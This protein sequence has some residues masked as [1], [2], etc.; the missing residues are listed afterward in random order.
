[1]A[2]YLGRMTFD[3]ADSFAEQVG[4]AVQNVGITPVPGAR[5]GT[6][7]QVKLNLFTQSPNDPVSANLLLRKQ[8]RS[9]LNNPGVLFRGLYISSDE[10]PEQNAWYVIQPTT[11]DDGTG[12]ST[13]LAAG[14]F[15]ASFQASKVGRYTNVRPAMQIIMRDRTSGLYAADVKGQFYYTDF[16]TYRSYWS[17]LGQ[18]I[19]SIAGPMAP[20]A[21]TPGNL[22]ENVTVVG[23]TYASAT[24]SGM[25]ASTARLGA[26]S[27]DPGVKAV[28]VDD[29][30]VVVAENYAAG[31]MPANRIAGDVVI[32]DRNKGVGPAR[33]LLSPQD[34]SFEWSVGSWVGFT[35]CTI[36]TSYAQAY[37]GNNSMAMTATANGNMAAQQP[38][39]MNPPTIPVIGGQTYTAVAY[40]RA[41]TVSRNATLRIEFGYGNP[42]S[43][44]YVQYVSSAVPDSSTGW[45][46]LTVTATAPA[47]AIGA[48]LQVYISGSPTAGE[49]HYVDAVGLYQGTN[50]TYS[51][52][53]VV[54]P[55]TSQAQPD[56]V[57][58]YGPDYPWDTNGTF[59]DAPV[60]TNGMVRVSLVKVGSSAR[61]CLVLE[62]NY[63]GTWSEVGR[64]QQQVN[65]TGSG[66]LGYLDT[67]IRGGVVEWRPDRGVVSMTF[68]S[69]A[70]SGYVWEVVVILQRGWLG[71]RVEVYAP[72]GTTGTTN[73]IS[74]QFIQ[75]SSGVNSTI[76]APIPGSIIKLN[77]TGSITGGTFTLTI[78]GYATGAITWSSTSAT[79]LANIQAAVRALGFRNAIDALVTS[80]SGLGVTAAIGIYGYTSAGSVT[81]NTGSL[82]GTG[83]GS[84][85]SV[86]YPAD[87]NQASALSTSTTSAVPYQQTPAVQVASTAGTG[88]TTLSTAQLPP[89]TGIN[90][91][92]WAFLR[93]QNATAGFNGVIMAS[94]RSTATVWAMNDGNA[95]AATHSGMELIC[96]SV[97]WF[98]VDYALW[99]GGTGEVQEIESAT[100]LNSTVSTSDANASGGY[101]AT[102][103]NTGSTQVATISTANVPTTG[104]YRVMVRARVGATSQQLATWVGGQINGQ[105]VVGST[106]S[107]T[108][109]WLDLGEVQLTSSSN[110]ALYANTSGAGTY[111]LDRL[112]LI[113]TTAFNAA[114]GGTV[115][116]Q[117]DPCFARDIALQALSDTQY[118]Q[119]LVSR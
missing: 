111:Y 103:T 88:S 77:L 101:A 106:N 79:L 69:S 2:F 34:S 31:L 36:A 117:N 73:T 90:S 65:F 54:L 108:Y 1:M 32:Y 44:T 57:E 71:P 102:N 13:G 68:G 35:N 20:A 92:S 50:T 15:T 59:Y 100:L 19:P 18:G 61:A 94:S 27:S 112:E 74:Q 96:P 43:P 119:T 23:A 75:A 17:S 25:A 3:V 21:F 22:P 24:S 7:Q 39:A 37:D 56:W 58:V 16:Q 41:A 84:S 62:G 49:V 9:L 72:G 12:S 66:T 116:S 42:S 28:Q 46:Q 67:F 80:P 6:T 95:Y 113:P 105:T 78:N 110:L 4:E 63:N 76:H 89:T 104:T 82:T 51:G 91:E 11:I 64:I 97:Q 107:T 10:D 109:V 8:L 30:Q 115:T 86:V 52:T 33:N 93:I 83:I 55:T 48:D 47:N 118:P 60:I 26:S 14:W 38:Y 99:Y 45:T 114:F 40:V 53:D 87:P 70:L 81:V 98:G 29:G 85:V 5:Q